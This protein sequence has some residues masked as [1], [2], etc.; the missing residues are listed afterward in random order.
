MIAQ[1]R[2][3][4]E[5]ISKNLTNNT[6]NPLQQ[7]WGNLTTNINKACNQSEQFTTDD[8]EYQY[9]RWLKSIEDSANTLKPAE[10]DENPTNIFTQNNYMYIESSTNDENDISKHQTKS[11]CSTEHSFN[12]ISLPNVNNTSSLKTFT[13]VDNNNNSS[14]VSYFIPSSF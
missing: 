11:Q 8:L 10:L 1:F 3:L 14:S 9:I 4:V 12:P 7:Q 6:L 5:D 2:R 13:Q